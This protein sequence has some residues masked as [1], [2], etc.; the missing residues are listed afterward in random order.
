MIDSLYQNHPNYGVSKPMETGDKW[1]GRLGG[2]KS[3]FQKLDNELHGWLLLGSVDGGDLSGSLVVLFQKLVSTKCS[4]TDGS[5]PMLQNVSKVV[6]WNICFIHVYSIYSLGISAS[7]RWRTH[8]FS[9][10]LN[11]STTR[12]QFSSIRGSPPPS[13]S[14]CCEVCFAA[15]CPPWRG[16]FRPWNADPNGFTVRNADRN[17]ALIGTPKK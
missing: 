16:L 9:E 13:R 7:R 15:V 11:H 3:D 2:L 4:A 8:S 6:V 12:C 1:A 5:P 10:G 17:S 14:D